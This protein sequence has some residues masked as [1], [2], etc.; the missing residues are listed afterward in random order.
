MRAAVALALLLA[1]LVLASGASA[2]DPK[3]PQQ[4][5]TVADTRLAHSIALKRSDLPSGWRPQPKRKP[6]P[7]CSSEPD[8]SNL[9]QTAR[10]DPT[11]LW[12]DGVTSVGSEVD[13]FKTVGQAKLDWRLSTLALMRRCLLE[14]AR[15]ELVSQQVTVKVLSATELPAPKLGE[16]SLHYRLVL[17]LHQAK[18][19]TTAP[20]VTELIAIG[21]GR[22]S[23]VVHALARGTAIPAAGLGSLASLL[24]KRLT[25]ASGGI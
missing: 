24:A 14:S 5:H 10:I 6:S 8:E 1:A 17:Q 13:I 11:F 20:I 4:R 18:T 16:R 15:R 3:E 25:N 2:R 19:K 23:V 22:I 21:V 12:A 9:V 7:P